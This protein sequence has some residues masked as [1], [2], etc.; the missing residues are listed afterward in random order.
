MT[1]DDRIIVW[2]DRGELVLGE[3]AQRSPEAFQSLARKSVLA[4]NDAW[5]HIVLAGDRLYCKDRNGNLN[6]FETKPE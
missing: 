2:A 4:E 3:T 6:C 1:S 5:P